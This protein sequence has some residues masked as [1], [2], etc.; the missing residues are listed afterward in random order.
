M[1]HHP[2]VIAEIAV[3]EVEER[4]Q[5]TL[6]AAQ[7]SPMDPQASSQRSKRSQ[8]IMPEGPKRRY[9]EVDTTRAPI[10]Q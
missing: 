7:A 8:C 5:A 4:H 1:F 9:G 2:E 3:R 10:R 6:V